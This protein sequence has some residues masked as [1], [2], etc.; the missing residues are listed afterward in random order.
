M[1]FLVKLYPPRWRRR[2]G[3]EFRA[4]AAAQPFS[5]GNTIDVV[6]GAIDAWISP[7]FVE[8]EETMSER[9]MKFRCA[10]FGPEVTKVDQRK[11]V[12]MTLTVT[13]ALTLVWM[14][15]HVRTHGNAYVDAFSLMPMFV[16]WL[17]GM[18][19]T[20]LRLRSG[21]AQAIFIAG[22][23]GML[24]LLFALTGWITSRI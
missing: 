18:R 7:Q 8:G 22:T 17:S 20:T 16:G 24:I 14:W 1:T 21:P 4:L 10:G 5:I 15:L 2:Y 19:Y 9:T 23:I 12:A 13:L 6:A 3:E 11:S